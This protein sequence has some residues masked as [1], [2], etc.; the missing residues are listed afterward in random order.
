M[1]FTNKKI[2]VLGL[3]NRSSIAWAIIK[4]LREEGAEVGVC[5]F[6]PSNQKRVEPLAAEAGCAFVQEV[7]VSKPA[8]IE[9]LSKVVSAK[10]GNFDGIV[11]SIAFAPQAAMEGRFHETTWEDFT[12]TLNISAYSLIHLC[13]NLKPYFSSS[14]SIVAMTYY[15]STK[16]LPGYNVMGVAKATLE[17]ICRYLAHD[18][19]PEGVRVNCISA[20]PIKTLA[21]LGVPNFSHFLEEIKA[22]S[23]LR[24]N[25]SSED[26][27]SLTSFLLSADATSITGQ[28]LFVDSGMST[29]LR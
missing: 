15:G 3:A 17:S 21:A 19:G 28:T 20:G 26:V 4:K 24:K 11:H 18:L 2:L 22:H 13:K 16:V 14:F 23:P 8:D 25:V 9:N 12:Q 1:K 6:H 29:I 10:W 5:Y 7:D 27:A